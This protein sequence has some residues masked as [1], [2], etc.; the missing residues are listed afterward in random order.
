MEKCNI[1]SHLFTTGLSLVATAFLLASAPVTAFF[2][3]ASAAPGV[4]SLGRR[5]A[6]RHHGSR[7][8]HP[9]RRL[10]SQL[11]RGGI[12]LPGEF[13]QGS[14]QQGDRIF[15]SSISRA[16][17]RYCSISGD[18]TICSSFS[19]VI[20]CRPLTASVL[21]GTGFLTILRLV[22]RSITLR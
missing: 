22:A 21:V 1:Y 9:A 15:S 4:F 14:S 10:F 12:V 7:L 13:F 18:S 5:C 11:D 8:L 17:A 3:T 2:T 20:R 6:A 16:N 19:I